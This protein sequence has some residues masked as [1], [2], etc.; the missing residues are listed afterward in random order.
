M[1]TNPPGPV[2]APKPRARW[3]WPWQWRWRGRGWKF[4]VLAGVGI[5]F[6]ILTVVFG[7]FYVSFSRMIDARLHGEMQRADPRV[8]A[9]PFQLRRGTV[10][11]A[12]PDHRP[13][14]RPRI[15]PPRAIGAARRV[16]CGTGRRADDPARRRPQ[17]PARPYR[18]RRAR[19]Q[20]GGADDDRSHRPRGD[21]ENR[22]SADARPA[23]HHGA[24]HFGARE[25]ARCA[26]RRD[27]GTDDPGGAR[28]RGPP[29]LRPR[30]RRP[31]RALRRAVQ[32]RLRPEDVHARRQ[33]PHAAAGQEHVPHAGT[34]ADAEVLRVD[35]VDRARAAAVQGP[36]PRALSE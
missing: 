19:A 16:H 5:P 11:D 17:G 32:L 25:A 27:P 35:H 29:F 14:Q 8:Y 3:R 36:G 2:V 15:L 1:A 22:R 31:H 20:R 6:L 26:A 13:A 34:V 18:V 23:A 30:G 12:D 7:Y 21:Q 10:P 33:H 24:H 4:Y 9:R 28:D